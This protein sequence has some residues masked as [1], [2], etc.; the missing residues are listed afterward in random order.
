MIIILHSTILY[1]WSWSYLINWWNALSMILKVNWSQCLRPHKPKE[2]RW[3]GKWKLIFLCRFSKLDYFFHSFI[4]ISY[5]I[6]IMIGIYVLWVIAIM[7]WKLPW[8]WI[9]VVLPSIRC[10]FSI[11][12]WNL[13]HFWV[14]TMYTCTYVTFCIKHGVQLFIVTQ[15]S[16]ASYHQQITKVLAWFLVIFKVLACLSHN[17]Q[18]L[19]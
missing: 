15:L 19:A 10:W 7:M 8:L 14:F 12:K 1:L 6:S 3:I 18:V 4:H 11:I 2:L 5:T 17:I 16:C 9:D 13:N